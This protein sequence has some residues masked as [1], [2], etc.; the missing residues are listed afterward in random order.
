MKLLTSDENNITKDKDGENVPC[1]KITE[2]VLVHFN[3]VNIYYQQDSRVLYTSVP[4]KS[5]WKF[6]GNFTNKFYLSKKIRSRI[7]RNQTLVYRSKQGIIRYI[8]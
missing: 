8:R 1:S 7:S 4:K 2:V 5:I 3:I 6:I